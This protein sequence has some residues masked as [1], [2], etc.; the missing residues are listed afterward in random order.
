MRLPC[1]VGLA[2]SGV[3]QASA[4]VGDT[5]TPGTVLYLV[6]VLLLVAG[7]LGGEA[8]R[9]TGR[10]GSQDDQDLPGRQER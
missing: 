9:L 5:A 6:L 4:L 2:V 7:A 3:L 8:A 10:N 1:V